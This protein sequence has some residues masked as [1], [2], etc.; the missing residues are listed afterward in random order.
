M[1]AR[2]VAVATASLSLAA[3]GGWKSGQANSAQGNISRDSRPPATA[4]ASVVTPSNDVSN[5]VAPTTN[6]VD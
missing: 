1:H 2:L 3:C 6:A 4:R 5:S